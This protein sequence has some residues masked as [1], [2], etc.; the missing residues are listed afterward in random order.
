MKQYPDGRAPM[1]L[2]IHLFWLFTIIIG[3]CQCTYTIPKSIPTGEW[4]YTLFVNDVPVGTAKASNCIV[5]KQYIIRSELRMEV[6][7]VTNIARQ[8][9]VETLDF[10]PVRYES[11][12]SIISSGETQEIDTVA[13]FDG[14]K[15]TLTADNS[16][17]SLTLPRD[18]MLDGNYFFSQLI[19]GKF[20]EGLTLTSNIYDPTIEQESLIPVTIT[21]IGIERIDVGG[22]SR[23]L[24]HLTESIGNVKSIDLYLDERGIM[25]KTVIRML[26]TAIVL[27]KD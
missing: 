8:T 25:I 20:K 16:S 5:D 12:N 21:V 6:G 4:T 13:T 3:M 27:I 1:K 14:R 9:I 23:R 11:H 18:F 22:E 7:D 26:N 15:V 2:R 17:A 19:E 24:I 10:K